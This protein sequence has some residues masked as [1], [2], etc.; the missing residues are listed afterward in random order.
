[1]ELATIVDS[2]ISWLSRT[3]VTTGVRIAFEKLVP[4]L[5]PCLGVAGRESGPTFPLHLRQ[6]AECKSPVTCRGGEL[7]P[8]PTDVRNT[9]NWHLLYSKKILPI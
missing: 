6:D 4:L 3:G 1:V 7:E 5:L 2:L 9:L 8:T